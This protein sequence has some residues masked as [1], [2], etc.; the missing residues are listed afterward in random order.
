MRALAAAHER[1][2]G[3]S[4]YDADHS[5]SIADIVAMVAMTGA[6]EAIVDMASLAC[7]AIKID[8]L[9]AEPSYLQL[10]AILRAR[11]EAREIPPEHALP[12]LT[13]LVQETGLAVGTVR[14][15]IKVLADEGLVVTV[16]GR[17]SFVIRHA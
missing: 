15:A 13:F 16:P 2:L 11:I 7:M 14:K 5:F 8:L 12:S 6:R 10:A 9:S 17:G 3:P 1:R 4:A